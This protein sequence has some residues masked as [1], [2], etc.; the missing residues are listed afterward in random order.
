MFRCLRTALPPF[1]IRLVER[2]SSSHPKI[3]NM[4]PSSSACSRL[5]I[6]RERTYWPANAGGSAT[7]TTRPSNSVSPQYLRLSDSK[8]VRIAF[9]VQRYGTEILGGA[10]YACRLTAER[11]ASRHDIEVLTTCARDY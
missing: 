1:P 11:L 7:S 8:S 10:E 6:I 3:S 5:K 2:A 9:I 4:R